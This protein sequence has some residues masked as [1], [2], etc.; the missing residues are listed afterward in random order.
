[1]VYFESET[2]LRIHTVPV[3]EEEEV[4]AKRIANN[5]FK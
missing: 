4:L 5:Y 2:S 1:M 3:E